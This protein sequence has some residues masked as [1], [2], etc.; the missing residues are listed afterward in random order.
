MDESQF[1]GMR[2]LYPVTCRWCKERVI[3]HSASK[4]L[5]NIN[6]SLDYDWACQNCYQKIQRREL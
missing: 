5:M 6:D 3:T 2:N 1:E 4:V